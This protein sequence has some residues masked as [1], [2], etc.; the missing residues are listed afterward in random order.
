[1]RA[2]QHQ[3]NMN[4]KRGVLGLD[5]VGDVMKMLMFLAI[6][7]FAVVIV[8]SVLAGTEVADDFRSNS[9]TNETGFLNSSGY[10]VD[11]ASDADAK[12]FQLNFV[13]NTT[14]DLTAEATIDS[15]GVVTNSTSRTMDPANISYSYDFNKQPFEGV[16]GNITTGVAEFFGNATTFFSILAA[17]VIILFV[18]LIFIGIRRFSGATGNVNNL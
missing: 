13:G 15:N 16:K 1:M 6:L 2:T 7:G 12:N 10:T 9:V 17:V 18:S 11:G 8:F 3:A 5:T 14:D 4:E